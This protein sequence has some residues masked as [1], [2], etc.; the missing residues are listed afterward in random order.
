MGSR[1]VG[2]I[3]TFVVPRSILKES[4]DALRIK[5]GGVR[6]S[7]VLWIGTERLGKALVCRIL[8]PCQIAS[9]KGFTVPF[10]ERVRIIQ[11]LGNSDQKLLA[12]LHTHPGKAFHSPTDDR[13]ALPR[14]TGAISIVVSDFAADWDG[15][16][17]NTSVN[18]HLGEGVWSELSSQAVSRLFEIK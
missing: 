13:I 11:E 4:A 14:H 16:L 3:H 18:Y 5:G 7:V 12:Q 8:L 6:E 15:D 10:D 17:Q 9:A 1:Y 2:G